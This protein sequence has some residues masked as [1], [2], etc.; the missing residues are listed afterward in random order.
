[1][2]KPGEK[3][4]ISV[5]V[6]DVKDFSELTRK[7][8]ELMNKAMGGH[9]NIL[10]KACH[11][12]AGYVIDQVSSNHAGRRPC[13]KKTTAHTPLLLLVNNKQHCLC[14]HMP[15]CRRE[16]AGPLHSMKPKMLWDS[17]CRCVMQLSSM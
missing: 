3:V 4:L 7:C 16:T 15:T 5:V 12:H 14:N 13:R 2:T 8:P 10:R 17:V 9:N 11:T 1:M 6:T